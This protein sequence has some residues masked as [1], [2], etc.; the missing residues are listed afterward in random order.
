[1]HC[2]VVDAVDA[3]Q[4]LDRYLV[5]LLP[6]YTR[7]AIARLILAGKVRVDGNVCRKTGQRVRSGERIAV[8][9]LK[10]EPVEL[11][12]EPVDF[13]VLHEDEHLMV[14]VKPPGLVVHP[15]AG[16]RHGTLA[17]GLLYHCRGLALPGVD[18]ARPGIVH[19]LDQD[20]SGVMLVAKTEAVRHQ[21]MA[22]F[23]DRAIGKTYVALLAR[24]PAADAGRIVA[25]L[26]RHPVHRT[27][28][29][30]REDSGKF[31]ATSWHILEYLAHGCCYVKLDLETGR[32]H[33]IRVHMASLG[34][35]VL[36]DRLY[37]GVRPAMPAAARQMLHAATLTFTHP[38]TTEG[39][40]FTAPL[41]ADMQQVLE[42]LR[43][44]EA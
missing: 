44:G 13:T 3:K 29:A 20:T 33:Q 10:E 16:H 42:T 21:L 27:K 1:M 30:V 18:S 32:T 23:K 8:R 12:P 40:Q 11:V 7:S 39:L 2:F 24:T 9:S 6:E 28:M 26:G 36:G 22:D 37:G 41:F 5:R 25:P 19:R 38:V 4:R 35:P 31:A 14:V 34:A 15:G 43:K 17:H